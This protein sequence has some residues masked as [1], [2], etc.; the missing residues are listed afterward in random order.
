[1]DTDI[2]D[3][4][5]SQWKHVRP[6]LDPK[7]MRISGRLLRLAKT[8]ERRTEAALRPF[9]LSMWQFDVLATL[10]RYDRDLSPGELLT[11]T[12]LTSGAMTHRLDRL[13]SAGWIERRPDPEDRRGVKVHLTRSGRTLVDK[14]IEARLEEAFEVESAMGPREADAFAEMLRK[15]EGTLS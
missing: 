1:M 9:D 7:P 4:L 5:I 3:L 13:E 2:I 8:I 15:L 6:D 14:A 11:A 12:M 10:R